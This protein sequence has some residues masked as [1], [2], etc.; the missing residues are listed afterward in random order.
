MRPLISILIPAHNSEAWLA[1]TVRSAQAQTWTRKE[2]IIVESGSRDR[3]LSVARQFAAKDVVVVSQ[4]NQ[5][6]SAARNHAFSLCQGDYI[7]WLDADDVLAPDKI[8]KQM[9]AADQDQ[10]RRVLLSGAWGDFMYRV[11]R[12][13]F[14]PTPLWSDLSP[15]E[16]LL[17]KMEN[18]AHMQTATWLVSRELTEAAGP[19]DIRLSLDDDGEYFCR[20][21]LASDCIR[22]V[23]EAKVFYRQ[24]GPNRLSS[25]D[26]SDK[27]LESLFLSMQLH[28]QYLRSL[29]DDE[30]AR[31]AALN[32]LRIWFIWFFK[33]RPDLADKLQQL[34]TE[35]GG[36]L[37]PPKLSWKYLW[38]QELFGWK[39]AKRT[40]EAWNR[41]K[42]SAIRCWDKAL[43]R[44]EHH[45]G[46]ALTV[47]GKSQ[48]G[49][50]LG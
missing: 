40:R 31:A 9:E 39:A 30:R 43:F 13:H 47:A 23:P 22:F 37:N 15:L 10:N 33:E 44:L 25:V 50:S 29:R 6:A 48:S 32:Y 35:L 34:A 5:G 3:T 38:I 7:Q 8:A 24:P 46:S 16:W 20:V 17:R 28:V 2:I 18:N 12:A 19:W 4:P 36:K 26:R 21:V 42:S 11:S 49:S 45:P 27:K 41:S 14:V 1:E